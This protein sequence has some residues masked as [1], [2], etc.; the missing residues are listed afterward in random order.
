MVSNAVTKKLQ[1]ENVNKIINTAKAI[2]ATL[3]KGGEVSPN[4]VDKFIENSF[5]AP[6]QAGQVA[7]A[8]LTN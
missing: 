2:N 8:L 1:P 7:G 4:L 5:L 3:A 6:Y